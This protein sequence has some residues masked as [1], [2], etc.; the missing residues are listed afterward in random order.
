M[1]DIKVPDGFLWE[2]SRDVAVSVSVQDSR[3][4]NATH[5]ISIYD[6]DPFNGGNVLSKG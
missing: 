5:V 2:S 4:G 3:Y 6:G 1:N